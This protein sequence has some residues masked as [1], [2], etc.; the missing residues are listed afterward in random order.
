MQQQVK[1]FSK[2][3]KGT[4]RTAVVLSGCGVND[5]SEV[6]ETVAM[7]TTLT[8]NGCNVQ[9]FAPDKDQ[10]HTIDHTTGEEIAQS[11]NVMVESARITRGDIKPLSEMKATGKA[12]IWLDTQSKIC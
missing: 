10:L 8:R 4:I 7:M 5:G 6:T 1:N 2:A 11:R 9:Y 3:N 12:I